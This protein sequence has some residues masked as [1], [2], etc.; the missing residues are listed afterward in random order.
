MKGTGVDPVL[1]TSPGGSYPA[2]EMACTSCHDPHGSAG[3]RLTYQDGQAHSTD[4]IT[5][6]YQATIVADDND[7]IP[8]LREQRI[9]EGFLDHYLF[10][11]DKDLFKGL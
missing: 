4:G 5:I 8:G 1:V 2:S 3:F 7:P 9:I 6:G 10:R 11:P